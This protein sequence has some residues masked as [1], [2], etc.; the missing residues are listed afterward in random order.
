MLWLF[1]SCSYA[2]VVIKRSW[3][4][5]SEYWNDVICLFLGEKTMEKIKTSELRKMWENFLRVKSET[6]LIKKPVLQNWF[7]ESHVGPSFRICL[8]ILR[9][10]W[11]L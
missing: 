6:G 9:D 4:Y 1:L 5:L 2:I 10:T 8:P 3:N 11:N 7:Q